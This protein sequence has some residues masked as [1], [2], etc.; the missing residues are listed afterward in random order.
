[1]IA[2]ALVASIF[3]GTPV[4]APY[5]ATLTR[6]SVVCGGALIAPDRVLTAAHCVQGADPSK[7]SV[8][9]GARRHAWRGAI[10]P[11]SYR[12]VASPVAP[13]DPGAAG[14]RDDIAV[15]L[16]REA[17]RDVTPLPLAGAAS[18]GEASLTVGRGRTGPGPTGPSA[19][20]LGASQ[21]VSDA[22]PAA[23]GRLFDPG[24]HLCT[25]APAPPAA[26]ACAG[27][28]GGPVMVSRGGVWAL[29]AVVTWGGET[30]GRDCG[31]GLP[32]VS[33]RVDVHA[34]LLTARGR[35]AP[36][37]ERRVRVRRSGA[38]RR[39]VLGRWHP[40]GARF[41]VRWW[42]EPGMFLTGGGRTRR[43]RSGRVG[44]SVTARTPGGWAT[45]DSYN[46]R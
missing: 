34:A 35:V 2:A 15:I 21:V 7:L 23:Y 13:E 42:R 17:V 5:V 3:A 46:R 9:L 12:L 8:R 28:S 40:A 14:S 38:V 39:C 36:W 43:V 6:A 16:L 20:P 4:D 27:D 11:R 26:Q 41:T 44:C 45:E 10:F 37:A 24:R 33:E 1:M 29:A 18:V 32:D 31:E 30:Q 25:V 19:V 22:C